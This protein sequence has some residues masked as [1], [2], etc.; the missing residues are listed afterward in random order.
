[1]APGKTSLREILASDGFTP[2][3]QKTFPLRPGSVMSCYVRRL[4]QFETT[5]NDFESALIYLHFEAKRMNFF[6]QNKD[7][8]LN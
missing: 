1:M 6:T 4:N 2:T 3:N 7:Q 8:R 5:N